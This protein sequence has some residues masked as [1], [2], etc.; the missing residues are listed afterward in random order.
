LTQLSRILELSGNPIAV[1]ENVEEARDIAV[2][3]GA[4]WEVPER[5]APTSSTCCRAAACDC[6]WS[7]WT[8]S[9]GRCT[10]CRRRLAWRTATAAADQSGVALQVELDPLLR[11]VQRKR[12]IRTAAMRRRDRL[13]LAVAGHHLGRS[14]EGV[15]TDIEWAPVLPGAALAAR[16]ASA[17]TGIGPGVSLGVREE[18]RAASP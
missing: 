6:T 13:A 2:Q 16:P 9:T 8:S 3:P 17:G 11:R 4:V 15:E 7:T 12:L 1:L 10:T 14:F 5:R 18:A